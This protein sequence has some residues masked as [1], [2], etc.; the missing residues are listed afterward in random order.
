MP[1][2]DAPCCAKDLNALKHFLE[3]PFTIKN[4][5]EDFK[6]WHL[7]RRRYYF[8]AIPV[9]DADWIDLFHGATKHLQPFM[10]S[11]YY[12]Q[13]HITIL[14]AGFDGSHNLKQT[15]LVEI[16]RHTSC[17]ELSLGAL[18]SFTSSAYFE[19]HEPSGKLRNL[20]ADLAR[21]MC[22]RSCMTEELE[23][24][25]H[26]TVGLYGGIYPTPLVA[27]LIQQ[28]AGNRVSA[29]MVRKIALASYQTSSVGGPIE[30]IMEIELESGRIY[31]VSNNSNK[32]D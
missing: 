14:P 19:V 24:V 9:D 12:R 28:F 6:S 27:D 11:S 17:F 29:I 30:V 1:S 2:A 8:W 7:G 26:M 22:D 32:N 16:C 21:V 13:P 10:L 4:V 5:D 18:S 15:P 25:P 23:F 20:R 31:W 3:H